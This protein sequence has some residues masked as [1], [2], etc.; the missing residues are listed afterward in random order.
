MRLEGQNGVKICNFEAQ[1]CCF[2]PKRAIL[3]H[4]NLNETQYNCFLL[5]LGSLEPKN[6]TFTHITGLL[7]FNSNCHYDCF[8]IVFGPLEPKNIIFTFKITILAILAHF[9][10]T[11][12]NW[13]Q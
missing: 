9:R 12:A 7:F 6:I 4:G 13:V 2:F 5:E 3:T 8:L 11:L 1:N 10:P